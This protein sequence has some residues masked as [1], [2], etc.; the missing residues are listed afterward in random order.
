MIGTSQDCRAP[1]ETL[2]LRLREEISGK[3]LLSSRSGFD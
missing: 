3:A 1:Q 2:I